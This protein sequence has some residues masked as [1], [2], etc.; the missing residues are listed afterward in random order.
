M[1]FND[2]SR[3]G[4][5]LLGCGKMGSAMLAGWVR[6]G[7]DPKAVWVI[8][9][10][11]S[12]WLLDQGVH[13]NQS[14]PPQPALILVAVKPQLMERAL[15]QIGAFGNA[16]ETVILSVAAGTP[17][18]TYE[19]MLGAQTPVIRAMPNTPAAIGKGITAMS[20]NS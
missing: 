12:D 16:P 6:D 18:K 19:D 17:I 7:L 11:P 3:R 15:P 14:L 8:D 5:V 4:L 20:A 13:V 1:T 10:Q 9:P 2:I